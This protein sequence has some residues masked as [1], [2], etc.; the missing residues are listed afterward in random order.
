[1][2]LP[3]IEARPLVTLNGDTDFA[4]VFFHDVRVP[5]DALLGPLNA[6]WQVATTTLSHER[7]GAARLYAEMQVR[8]EELVEDLRSGARARRP[9]DAAAPWRNRAPHQVSRGALPAVDLGDCTAEMRL[10][11]PASPRPCG[12]RS[13]KTW[14]PWPSTCWAPRWQR[15][16]RTPPDV[17]LADIAAERRQ[18]NKNITAQ[19]VLGLPAMNLE[20]TDEQVAL[21]ESPALLAEKAPISGHVRELLD[22]PTGLDDAVW[23]GLP[24]SG[25]PG[26]W[27]RRI[28]WRRHDDGRGRRRRRRTRRRVASGPW[29]SKAVAATRALTR[30]GG[31][32]DVSRGPSYSAESPTGRRSPPSASWIRDPLGLRGRS[33]DES[34][35]GGRWPQFPTPPRPTP[36]WCSPR[37]LWDPGSMRVYGQTQPES[38]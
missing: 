9:G 19:R 3:G 11:R 1:M 8:L 16:G 36:R 26:C 29:L 18:I 24:T 15:P 30:L 27:C 33:G 13:G 7:A 4:E 10:R 12:V 22:D 35:R 34:R 2:T 23:R 37:T 21:R 14:R 38:R 5:A 28:R 31:G 17:A 25:R 6:G 20:L 32:G